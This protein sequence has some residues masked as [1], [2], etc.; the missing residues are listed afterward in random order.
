MKQCVNH[1]SIECLLL[2][3]L[4]IIV[5]LNILDLQVSM[6]NLCKHKLDC[7]LCLTIDLL[8]ILL[9]LFLVLLHLQLV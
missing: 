5:N 7:R 6:L 2:S 8:L 1:P 4:I 9:V 3:N